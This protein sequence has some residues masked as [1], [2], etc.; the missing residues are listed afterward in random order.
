[1]SAVAWRP[2]ERAPVGGRFDA[3]T[4]VLRLPDARGVV[5]KPS[6]APL[7][8]D[9]TALWARPSAAAC[10]PLHPAGV[11]ELHARAAALVSGVLDAPSRWTTWKRSWPGFR[12]ALNPLGSAADAGDPPT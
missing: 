3:E 2:P 1:M 8:K 11:L 6:G 5:A 10:F 7:V 9:E 4:G 12:R